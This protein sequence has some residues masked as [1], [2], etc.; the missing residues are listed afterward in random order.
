M[1]TNNDD[2]RDVIPPILAAYLFGR[3]SE[4]TVEQYVEIQSFMSTEVAGYAAGLSALVDRQS[5]STEQWVTILDLLY[6]T[7]AEYREASS[8]LGRMFYDSQRSKHHPE[9]PINRVN[10][11]SYSFDRFVV[12]MEPA[13]K[14]MQKADSP[15]DAVGRMAA[16]AV[17]AVEN[18]GRHQIIH[19]VES[20][21]DLKVSESPDAELVKGWARVAVG[22]YTCSWCLMLVS[23][24]PVYLGADTAGL[25]L[26]DQEAVDLH[27]SGEDV[28]AFM[29]AWHLNCDCKVVP[30]FKM[31]NWPGKEQAAAALSLWNAA[32]TVAENESES[33][34]VKIH[35]HG[36]NKGREFTFNQLA[37]NALRRRLDRGDIDPS[38]FALGASPRLAA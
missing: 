7:V 30:V 32:V 8:F 28:S 29:N 23:R 22:E 16:A 5:L 25:N 33:D 34:D 15:R 4:L 13:R 38:K 21:D 37:L 17:K 36:K 14:Q 10:L 1:P 26:D 31:S 19:A 20:D 2:D 12:D 27:H 11:E 6:P 18:A 35:T 9:L 3:P 24:G